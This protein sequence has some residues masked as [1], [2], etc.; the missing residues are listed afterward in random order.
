MFCK[1]YSDISGTA[2][3]TF[4]SLISTKP[5]GFW[6]PLSKSSSKH[7]ES[8]K[9][10]CKTRSKK[11]SCSRKLYKNAKPAGKNICSCVYS[12]HVVILHD[13]VHCLYTNNSKINIGSS[14]LNA[15]TILHHASQKSSAEIPMTGQF[16]DPVPR[17]LRETGDFV[18]G[19]PAV[20]I[21]ATL[22]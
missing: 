16:A 18:N 17:V 22:G 9:Q 1:K 6:L 10:R 19:M 8:W 3:V 20:K 14:D 13:I 2:V 7:W 21:H 11:P 4:P 15:Q 12:I 5:T